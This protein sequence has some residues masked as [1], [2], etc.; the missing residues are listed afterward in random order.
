[1]LSWQTYSLVHPQ[2]TQNKT[3]LFSV[4]PRGRHQYLSHVGIIPTELKG[5][6]SKNLETRLLGIKRYIT[7]STRNMDIQIQKMM[8]K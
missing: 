1:M 4:P 5:T 2:V 7:Q 6:A 8:S 3:V